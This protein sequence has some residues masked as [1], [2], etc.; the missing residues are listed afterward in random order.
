MNWIELESE[1]NLEK[2]ISDSF[3]ENNLS[4][5]IFK[6]STRCSI[7]SMAKSRLSSKWNFN[8]ELPIYHLDLIQAKQKVSL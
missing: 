1:A 8:E 2:I 5:A 7:S 6:H 3:L 4:V